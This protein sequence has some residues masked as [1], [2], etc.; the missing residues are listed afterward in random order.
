MGVWVGR[1]EHPQWI[2]EAE[3]RVSELEEKIHCT[4]GWE[5]LGRWDGSDY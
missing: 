3:K 4:V 5:R 1:Q 2:Q